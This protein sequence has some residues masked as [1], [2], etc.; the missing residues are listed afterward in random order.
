MVL[1]WSGATSARIDIHRN[2]AVV[3]DTPNDGRQTVNRKY[4]SP[5]TYVMKVCESGTAICSNEVTL[6]FD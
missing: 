4:S 2:G 6:V 5:A 1:R 3:S